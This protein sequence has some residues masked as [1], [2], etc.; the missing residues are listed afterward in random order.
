[1][2]SISISLFFIILLLS[3]SVE[4][5]KISYGQEACHFCKMTIVDRQ[6]AAQIVT[7]KGKAYKYDAAECMINDMKQKR[8]TEIKF[9]LVN[10]YT[11]PSVLIDATNASYIISAA[12]QSPMG[13]NLSAFKNVEDANKIL[14]ESG[15]ELYN[16]KEIVTKLN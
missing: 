7:T 11:N 9:H 16:W 10:D 1:M 6:H 12:I 15:G 4:P 8:D 3:C 2:K 14:A 13:A 5:E